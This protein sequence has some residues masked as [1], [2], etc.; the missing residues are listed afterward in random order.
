MVAQTTFKQILTDKMEND[1][2]DSNQEQGSHQHFDISNMAY[3]LGKVGRL[4][5][6][7]PRGHYPAPKVRPQRKPH[8]FSES[9]RCAFDFF[10]LWSTNLND[11]FSETELKKAFRQIVL[12][13]HPDRGG[14][15]DAFLNLKMHYDNLRSLVVK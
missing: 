7:S 12:V 13:L 4:N 2:A 11:N 1:P 14:N 5:L 6:K 3:L 10:K 9:Q 8:D 15:S